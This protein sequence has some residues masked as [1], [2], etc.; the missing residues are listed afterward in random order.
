MQSENVASAASP[1]QAKHVTSTDG[2]I[3]HVV[4]LAL[5]NRSFDH[6]LGY[7]KLQDPRI[8]GISEAT[9]FNYSNPATREQPIYAT[10]DAPYV[11]DVDPP[12]SHEFHDVLLQVFS[13]LKVP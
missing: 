8:E 11:P 6:M 3:E 13:D 4:V 5:E 7:L 2:R 1:A 12:P 9:A 10:D